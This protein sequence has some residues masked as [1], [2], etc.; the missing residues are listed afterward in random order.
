MVQNSRRIKRLFKTLFTVDEHVCPQLAEHK[1]NTIS[2][3][4][5]L[6]H[7]LVFDEEDNVAP[8]A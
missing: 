2:Y 4:Y 5:P 6:P 3:V 1:K 8:S 7:T